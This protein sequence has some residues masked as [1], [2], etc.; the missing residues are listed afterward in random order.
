M[1]ATWW[2]GPV[3]TAQPRWHSTAPAETNVQPPVP[4]KRGSSH[5]VLQ[6]H[7]QQDPGSAV[8]P[9]VTGKLLLHHQE[10]GLRLRPPFC[11][12]CGHSGHMGDWRRLERLKCEQQEEGESC[13]SCLNQAAVEIT[14]VRGEGCGYPASS[15]STPT[16]QQASGKAEGQKP[17]PEIQQGLINTA[18]AQPAHCPASGQGSPH[19][20]SL[21][22]ALERAA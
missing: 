14:S 5:R 18:G 11:A 17:C 21:G 10:Q 22:A 3:D 20:D 13:L 6:C 9:Q 16:P 4:Q 8:K 12:H 2:H 15:S 7:G 19:R 1:P